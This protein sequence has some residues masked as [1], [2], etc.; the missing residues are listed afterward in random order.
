MVT[1]ALSVSTFS[2]P[3]EGNEITSPADALERKSLASF[4]LANRGY[5]WMRCVN[6]I[7]YYQTQ[8]AGPNEFCT[9]F[10]AFLEFGPTRCGV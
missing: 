8:P 9:D 6:E 4:M 5:G 2:M 10:A 3:S 1:P 7:H